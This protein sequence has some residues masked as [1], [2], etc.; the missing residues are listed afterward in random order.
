MPRSA[1]A[2]AIDRRTPSTIVNRTRRGCLLGCSI[3]TFATQNEFA[4]AIDAALQASALTPDVRAAL[5]AGIG[6]GEMQ[7]RNDAP[8]LDGSLNLRL[9][10]WILREQDIPVTEIIG[11]VGAAATVALAPGVIAA[12]AVITALS[13]FAALCWKA[14][15]KGA[16]LS[17]A[18][19]AVLGF[20][21]VQGPM[22][23]EDLKAKA[24]AALDGLTAADVEHAVQSLQDVELRDGNIVE[25]LRKDGAGLWR[26][27]P[28]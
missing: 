11:V 4:D 2:A 28:I 23:L 1:M 16:K 7:F 3:R 14:W 25:L 13:T 22:S 17:R 12:G 15:R 27:R 24:P 8:K 6:Q 20:L 10:S 19:I 9:N 18:E 21:Q 26:A 5:T